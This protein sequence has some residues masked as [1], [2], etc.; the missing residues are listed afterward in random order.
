MRIS[1]IFSKRTGMVLLAALLISFCCANVSA[2]E[3]DD[4]DTGTAITVSEDN[5]VEIVSA[6]KG[7]PYIGDKTYNLSAYWSEENIP[8]ITA[9][10]DIGIICAFY[11]D[12]DEDGT[13]EIF[14]VTYEPSGYSTDGGS[15]IRFTVYKRS[16]A[17]WE[18]I[19]EKEVQYNE[20]E[21]A[22]VSN[23][24]GSS[25]YYDGSVFMRKYNGKYEFFYEYYATGIFASGQSWFLRGFR[26]EDGSLTSIPE[27][28]KIY[29]LGSPIYLLWIASYDDLR[30]YGDLPIIENYCALGFHRPDINAEQ[31]TVD[32]Q[33]TLYPL[34][35]MKFDSTTSIEGVMDWFGERGQPLET[36]YYKISDCT[37]NL[38]GEIEEFQ[39]DSNIPDDQTNEN[40]KLSITGCSQYDDILQKYI[41]GFRAGWDQGDFSE[42]GLC[43]LAAH[44]DL[45]TAGYY[46]K[47]IDG[48][49]VDELFIS[50]NTVGYTGMFW[51]LYTLS[52][53]N[54]VLVT[55][56]GE[57][58]RYYLC[59]DNTIAN[60]N[61][62]S[63][64]LSGWVYYDL[65][66]SQLSIKESVNYDGFYNE[67]APWFYSD[68]A[69]HGDYSTS[70]SEDEAYAI[71]N[72]YEYTDI[73]YITFASVDPNSGT[74]AENENDP[75]YKNTDYILP[76]SSTT[77][78][79][80]EQLLDMGLS[81]EQLCFAR[82]EIFA[83]HGRKFTTPEIQQ[84]FDSKSWYI[85]KYTPEEFEAIQYDVLNEYEWA[86][87]ELISSI[88]AE[89]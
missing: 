36:F 81:S 30:E 78:I 34:V 73:P 55:T 58:D 83:K 75:T 32:Q 11:L 47:D 2:N 40:N 70:I 74:G 5:P 86:N 84:Y 1:K 45:S 41:D 23:M 71:R 27:T 29:Y 16:E 69:E 85:P 42:N 28:E 4:H 17:E 50:G 64:F 10:N 68:S 19:S 39:S 76:D 88:E 53:D 26:F 77:Y 6:L 13:E 79:S 72:S 20:G 57:R 59:V 33:P 21:Y 65:I 38:T 18:E 8:M 43:Y 35:R 46:L 56:S 52:G 15:A 22:D 89:L 54:A 63:A 14:S 44:Q 51:D 25:L 7:I 62:G 24:D 82:N 37:K 12:L 67:S 87:I 48:N 80:R 66:G 60:E 9:T 61:S 31:L 3:S 49:G